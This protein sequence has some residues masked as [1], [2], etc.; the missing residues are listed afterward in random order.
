MKAARSYTG[1]TLA[2][3]R[4]PGRSSSSIS[5]MRNQ[6]LVRGAGLPLVSAAMT[7]RSRTLRPGRP[8]LGRG[9][10]ARYACALALGVALGS[11]ARAAEMPQEQVEA[12]YRETL[13][14]WA[15]GDAERAVADLMKL[16][17]AVISDDD[18]GS[19]TRLHK[20]Q[21]HV[22]SE[23]AGVSLEILVPIAAL[24]QEAYRRYVERGGRGYGLL[25]SHA[26]GLAFDLALLYQKHTGSEGSALV[27]SRFLTSLAGFGL[28]SFQAAKLFHQAAELDGGNTAALL[29][30]A[31]IF[32]KNGQYESAANALRRLLK[33]DP[34]HPEARLRLALCVKR[35]GDAKEARKILEE[36]VAA[37]FSSWVAPLV[38]EELALLLVEQEAPGEAETVLRAA[39]E[40]YPKSARLHLQLA[41]VLDRKGAM[42]EGKAVLDR[43]LEL[44]TGEDPS[45]GRYNRLDAGLF[46]YTRRFLDENNRSRLPVLAQALGAAPAAEAAR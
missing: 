31:T 6:G 26:R 46:T 7:S 10:L 37:S 18:V 24:H 20:A 40:R 33:T 11:P 4:G 27:A 5:F 14:S 25:T 8:A 39:L 35:M 44:P 36:L 23:L 12:R 1:P 32:E 34:Q 21:Q 41:A 16:E 29:G 28:D 45:R 9:Q 2:R 30:L 22:I 19:R 43:I 42:N 17:T 15:A 13:V 38:A 3:G